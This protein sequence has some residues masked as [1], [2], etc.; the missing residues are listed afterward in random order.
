MRR[1]TLLACCFVLG[2]CKTVTPPANTWALST[3]GDSGPANRTVAR[4]ADLP[5]RPF[6][7][8][9]LA[10]PP[11]AD[12]AVS[13]NQPQP[14]VGIIAAT[15]A[16]KDARSPVQAKPSVIE[17]EGGH[18]CELCQHEMNRVPP[19]GT[20]TFPPL[21]ATRHA[22]RTVGGSLPLPS[23]ASVRHSI[24][25]STVSLPASIPLQQD[26]LQNSRLA[27]TPALSLSNGLALPFW[28]N[29]SVIARAGG[30]PCAPCA[31]GTTAVPLFPRDTSPRKEN[32]LLAEPV[33]LP[34]LPST[35]QG[36]VPCG[37]MLS[38]PA[39]SP[40]PFNGTQAVARLPLI[41]PQ[42]VTDTQV[43]EAWRAAELDRQARTQKER[44]EQ[45][46]QFRRA[47]YHFLSVDTG[48]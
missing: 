28:D 29:S 4:R 39:A 5:V 18:P 27:R 7:K 10:S 35:R 37:S 24:T 25:N 38:L 43:Q 45:F 48:D 31:T 44:E 13:T 17:R 16:R 41:I 32:H 11:S 30:R 3:G 19:S 22:E 26:S 20:I 40:V 47:F 21:P 1:W 9:G 6:E 8:G 46:Q 23:S 34:T 42:W 2:A 36:D 14:T 15:P 33:A 12:E